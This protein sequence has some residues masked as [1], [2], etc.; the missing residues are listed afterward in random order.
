MC[1]MDEF[2]I[3]TFEERSERCGRFDEGCRDEF[4]V[5]A[6]VFGFGFEASL[7]RHDCGSAVVDGREEKGKRMQVESGTAYEDKYT[8]YGTGIAGTSVALIWLKLKLTTHN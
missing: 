3:E 6:R 8:S 2:R 4:L 5:D 1:D 7:R